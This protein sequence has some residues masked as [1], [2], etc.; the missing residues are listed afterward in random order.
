[1]PRNS[2]SKKSATNGHLP[3]SFIDQWNEACVAGQTEYYSLGKLRQVG[4]FNEDTGYFE[5]N[6][7]T[8]LTYADALEIMK[9]GHVTIPSYAAFGNG[10]KVRTNLPV[11][12]NGPMT[13]SNVVIYGNYTMEVLTVESYVY[14]DTAHFYAS[15]EQWQWVT[16]TAT[17]LHTVIGW[18]YL[19][20]AAGGKVF[21]G[22][23]NLRFV[24]FMCAQNISADLSSNPLLDVSVFEFLASPT[25]DSYNSKFTLHA[26]T[27]AKLTAD[28]GSEVY[29]NLPEDEKARWQ[30][31]FEALTAKNFTFV[32]A[33]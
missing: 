32:C 7:L 18:V 26:D 29:N 22:A 23:P 30:A 31:A 10:S 9:V 21:W 20:K 8:D 12:I 16:R 14:G 15:A 19:T 17:A 1:M 6:G 2:V 11:F 25:S 24:N 5:L 3:Q 4:T 27:Y 13:K 28:T 33:E